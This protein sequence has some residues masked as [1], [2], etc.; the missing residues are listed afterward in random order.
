M[1]SVSGIRG[2]VGFGLTPEVAA[3]YAAAFGAWAI[4]RGASRAVVLG[5][6]SRVTGPLFHA[7]TKAALQSVGADVIDIGLTTTPTLQ[8]AVEHHHAAGGLGI[9]ASHNPI[10]W[11]ALKFIGPDGLFLSAAQGAEMRALV[12]AGVPYATWDR[13]GTI[14]ED[15]GA[16]DRH[17]DQVLALP[18]LDVPGIRAR[19]FRV[20]FD[21][22]RGAGGAVIPRLLERL[23]CEVHG[24]ELEPDGRFPRPPE[25]VADHL[26]DLEALVRRTGAA[27][28]F[29]T[30]PDVDRLA[31]VADDGRAIGEDYT[32]ALATLLVLRHRPGPVVTNLSTSRIVDDMA[33]VHG[34]RVQRAPVGEVNVALAMRAAG[35]VIG[36]EGNGGVILPELHLGR[37]APLGVA[38]LLQ[39]LHEEAAPLSAI[40]GRFPRYA[41]LKDKLDRP[42]RPL[43]AV[44]TA[45]TA[46]FLDAVADTQDGLRLT[47]ADR[48]IH[49]RP[50]GT[51]P[52][53]RVIA[54]APTAP[55]AQA[56]VDRGRALLASLA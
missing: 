11:N 15:A 17:L 47:W 54:E 25:P 42:D 37:D 33:A 45:L 8:L 5:R 29:A 51:E 46:A 3:R 41:I 9:T 48:W 6:D 21:A 43:D 36:G 24:I 34:G 32:L 22:C 53:V 26:G 38:L 27:I 56:L 35:A 31:L 28:G 18:F 40:V 16:I 52:I 7:V 23:G 12:D 44:Y 2:R 55:E 19:R 10:E 14:Q 4:G 1:I 50:S 39:L 49:V 20:A 30:D 13:L